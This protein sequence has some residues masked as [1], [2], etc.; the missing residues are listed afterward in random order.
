LTNL[1]TITET[2]SDL[3][4]NAIDSIEDL[5]RSAGR[6]LDNVRDQTGD[7]L[8]AAASSVRTTGRQSSK[9]I[10]E[11]TTD[12]AKRLDATASYIE[13]TD[14]TGMFTGVRNYARRYP[15][16]SLVAAA[17][18]G[19]FVGSAFSRKTPTRRRAS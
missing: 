10:D 13:D 7:A 17:A 4:K 1:D 9:A 19:F 16:R 5:R 8:H 15:T 18:I 12:A 14:L 3:G 2:A 11:F 6:K